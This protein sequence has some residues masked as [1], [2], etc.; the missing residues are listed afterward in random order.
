MSVS[1]DASPIVPSPLPALHAPGGPL[2]VAAHVADPGAPRVA[3]ARRALER[4]HQALVVAHERVL[5]ARE[6][7]PGLC[8]GFPLYAGV[9]TSLDA[10]GDLLARRTYRVAIAGIMSAGKST[11]ANALLRRPGLLPTG[12]EETT[13][14]ITGVTRAPDEQEGFVVHYLTREEAIR[15]V[16]ERGSYRRYLPP[17]AVALARDGAPP[18]VLLS[19]LVRLLREHELPDD[20]REQLQGFVEALDARRAQLGTTIRPSLEDRRLYL[21]P[22]THR[23]VGHLLLIARAEIL[24]HNELF[25]REG[26]E[27]VDLPGADSTNE[28]QQQITWDYLADTDLLLAVPN[29]AGFRFTDVDVLARFREAR[30]GDTRRRV[31]FVV[32]RFDEA[33]IQD[34]DSREAALAYF[35]KLVDALVRD[36]DP[37][38]LFFAVGLWGQLEERRRS[39]RPTE[40]EARELQ[41]VAQAT[42]D[43]VN[44]LERLGV[45]DTIAHEWD[46]RYG[47]RLAEALRALRQTGGVDRLRAELVRSLKEDLELERLE[48]VRAHLAAAARTLEALIGPERGRVRGFLDSARERLKATGGYLEQ[49]AFRTRDAVDRAHAEAVRPAAPDEHARGGAAPEEAPFQA[50]L[51]GLGQQFDQAIETLLGRDNP[52]LDVRQLAREAGPVGAQEL[53]RR[54]IDQARAVLSQRFVD[55]VTARISAELARRYQEALEPLENERILGLLGRVLE[56]PELER[57]YL[58]RLNELERTLALVTRLRALEETW[59]VA[60]LDFHPSP[61]ARPFEELEP[62]FRRALAAELQGVFAA[63]FQALARVLPRYYR[64]VLD[65][66]VATFEEL[67][68]EALREARLVGAQIPVELLAAGASEEDRARFGVAELVS[69]ADAAHRALEAVALELD[70]GA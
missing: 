45:I 18:E 49:V 24:V 15:G 6:R 12:I 67:T 68:V 47:P 58:A 14:T 32:N 62:A 27:L 11:L 55:F 36:Y 23:D 29:S 8:A 69:V 21:A 64:C 1:S 51:R 57:R 37:G 2:P 53:M 33:K 48:E 35:K 34:L 13:L 60:E 54:V 41:R 31:F 43:I 61:G 7:D 5:A 20:V 65:D 50:L 3:R 4:A 46:E 56:R 22:R 42:V 26:L 70:G 52:R 16:Y 38:N 25:A 17:A 40:E 30:G 28:R 19:E 44:H 10:A 66:F 39:V 59:A 9:K 63:R